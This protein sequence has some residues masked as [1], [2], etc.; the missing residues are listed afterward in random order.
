[1]AAQGFIFDLDGTVWDS[2]SCYSI[3]LQHSGCVTVEQASRDLR[4]GGNVIA[5]ARSL[6]ISD[7][8][9]ASLCTDAI[10]TLVLYPGVRETLDV[11]RER[12]IS[13]GIATNLP[14]WLAEPILEALKLAT[15]FPV[16]VYAARKPGAI[17]IRTAVQQLGLD[18][19]SVVFYV[20]DTLKDA[21][22]AERAELPFAW[23]AYGYGDSRPDSAEAVLR[24]FDEVL[25]L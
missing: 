18:L 8:H 21:L 12:Q 6:N 20:G 11:L 16:C 23:A 22:A 4:A 14:R 24:T 15:H 17:G 1:M 25:N 5:L 19:A 2:H 7:A 13:L 9:F 3:A 10:G